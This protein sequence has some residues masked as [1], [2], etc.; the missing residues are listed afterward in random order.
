MTQYAPYRILSI[1]ASVLAFFPLL[2][3]CITD[4]A[5]NTPLMLAARDGDTKKVESLLK[6][7]ADVNA[8]NREGTTALMAA[9]WGKTGRGD[10]GIAKALIARG[11]NVN[12]T[13]VY[14]RTALMDVAGNGNVEFV[15]LLLSAG[16]DVNIQ[17]QDGGTALH[18]ATPNGHIEIV[19][20]LLTKGAKPNTANRRG[21]TPLMLAC[22][23]A[24]PRKT[25]P[26]R[27]DM[28]RLLIAAGADVN[29]KDTHGETAL[30]WATGG[31]MA[32]REEIKQLLKNAGAA[33]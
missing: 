6:T 2:A 25:C 26:W 16:A 28:V 10:V 1:I 8:K 7:G 23:C 20:M 9:T 13:N 19:R 33:E 15:S 17:T 31:T 5:G 21:Q 27:S 24:G 18:E 14:G 11:A 12:A 32:E 4:R 29:N 30:N 3:G 22:N